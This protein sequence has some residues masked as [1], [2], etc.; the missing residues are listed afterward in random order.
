MDSRGC[1]EY[2]WSVDIKI[3]MYAVACFLAYW[4]H[5]VIKFPKE[6]HLIVLCLAIYGVIC[7][8]HYYLEK[9]VE[10][11]AFY[12]VKENEVSLSKLSN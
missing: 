3:V 12:W 8:V 5:F 10:K 6:Y 11:E 4:S 2:T 1:K 7:I 9:I